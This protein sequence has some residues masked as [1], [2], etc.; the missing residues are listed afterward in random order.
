M[1]ELVVS[2]PEILG[3]LVETG[4][5][6]LLTGTDGREYGRIV[7]FSEHQR[8]AH[9][10]PS[11]IKPLI[12]AKTTPPEI[13]VNPPE[14]GRPD[15]GIDLGTRNMEGEGNSEGQSIDGQVHEIAS[16]HPKILDAFHLTH[17]VATAIAEA[18]ARDGRDLVWAGTKSMAD[19]V[20]KWP[21]EEM[22]FLPSAQRYFRESQYRKDPR[23]WERSNHGKSKSTN[24][25][26]GSESIDYAKGADVVFEG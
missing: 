11:K 26:R 22:Q 14:T 25:L 12:A 17:E 6:E 19:V 9:P 2:I 4:Y 20:A 18:I 21:K 16:L 5:L 24:A 15:L 13:L 23:E 7:N 1:R 8:V 10:S 3:K